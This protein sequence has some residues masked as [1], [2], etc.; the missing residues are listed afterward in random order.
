MPGEGGTVDAGSIAAAMGPGAA[1]AGGAGAA[2]IGGGIGLAGGLVSS[3]M[4]LYEG[5]QNRRFQERMSSTAH[6]REVADLKAAGLNPIL[7]ATHGGA[8]TPGGAMPQIQNPAAGV[9]DSVATAMRLKNENMLAKANFADTMASMQLKDKQ[10]TNVEANTQRVAFQQG[11]DVANAEAARASAAYS[12]A[13]VGERE[14][15]SKAWGMVTPF[16]DT[17]TRGLKLL[18]DK[19]TGPNLV[20]DIGRALTSGVGTMFG[21]SSSASQFES[22]ADKFVGDAK[23]KRDEREGD[24]RRQSESFGSKR[25]SSGGW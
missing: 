8:S 12:R 17:A 18:N 19:L 6:Q 25:G 5:T 16:I 13:G 20:T 9:P 1:T 11:L 3:A 21:G 15:W 24:L 4:N 22:Q 23:K 2:L 7:S 14:G 10:A